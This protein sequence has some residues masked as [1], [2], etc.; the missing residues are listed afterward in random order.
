VNK[1]RLLK[2]SLAGMLVALAVASVE[3]DPSAGGLE[4]FSPG[5]VAAQTQHEQAASHNPAMLAPI[6]TA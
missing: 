2:N 1:K 4:G 3:A 6:T 5:A